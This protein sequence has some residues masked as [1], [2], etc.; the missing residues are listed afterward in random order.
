MTIA[1]VR[2]VSDFYDL[3][4]NKDKERDDNKRANI[5]HNDIDF[6]FK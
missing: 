4:K 3:I 2:D 6:V 5:I 1:M